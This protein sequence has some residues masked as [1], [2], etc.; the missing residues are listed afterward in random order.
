MGGLQAYILRGVSSYDP[1]WVK[2]LRTMLN[3]NT[4]V[5]AYPQLIDAINQEAKRAN[6]QRLHRQE[7]NGRLSVFAILNMC[8]RGA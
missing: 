1:A 8:R 5:I 4:S 6:Y 7:R 3:N 2:S